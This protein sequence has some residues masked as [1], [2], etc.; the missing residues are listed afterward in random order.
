VLCLVGRLQRVIPSLLTQRL[1]SLSLLVSSL[2]RYLVI[3]VIF[4]HKKKNVF[5]IFLLLLI[6]DFNF[7]ATSR[8]TKERSCLIL[9][10][11]YRSVK[12]PL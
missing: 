1:L 5:Y 12:I 7:R 8:S 3:V 11:C 6:P 2:G 9:N 10:P 4:K